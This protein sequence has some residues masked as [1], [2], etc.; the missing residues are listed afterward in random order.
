MA[1][2]H[3]GSRYFGPTDVGINAYSYITHAMSVSVTGGPSIG[4]GVGED[5]D[6]FDTYLSA[7]DDFTWIHG[8]H[9]LAFG[10]NMTHSLISALA[11]VRA[12]GNYTFN[13]QTTGLGSADFMAGFL[14]QLVQ[15]RPNPLYLHQWFVG[16]YAQD[17]WK[18]SPRLTLNAGLRWEP[19]IPM[20]LNDKSIYT[21]S[22]SRHYAGIHSRVWTNAPAGFYYPGDPG[23]NGD[24]GIDSR[25][26]DL[27]PRL[28]LAWDPFGDGKTSIRAGAGL[29]YDFINEQMYLNSDLAAPFY[30]QT[31]VN[32]SIP[33]ANPWSA[34]PT[35]NP[36]PYVSSPPIGT[37]PAFSSFLPLIPNL[38]PPRT[39]TWNAMIQRQV[40]PA[41]FVSA[42]YVGSHS[43]HLFDNIELNPGVYIPGNCAA[44]QYGLTA[45]GPCSNPSNVNYRR[46]LYL[47]YPAASQDIANLTQFDDG[48]TSNYNGLILT[49]Q[50]RPTSNVN[51]NAN[52][53][54]SHCIGDASTGDGTNDVA[55][56]YVHLSDRTLDR[57]NCS[58]D[59]RN[60]FNLTVVTRTPNFANR[61]LHMTLTG[62]SLSTI[63]R[64]SSGASVTMLAG[65]DQSLAGFAP[66][67]GSS[68]RPNQI[69]ANTAAPN[70]GRACAN[71]A[72]CVSWLNPSAFAEPAPGTLGN[73]GTYN[74]VG[75]SYFQLD[76]ALVRQF[77]IRESQN[78]QFR[79]EAFNLFN[80]TRLNATSGGF[81]VS[82]PFSALISSNT[83]GRIFSAFDPRILQLAMK[84]TF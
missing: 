73:M 80:N 10:A 78:L 66:T 8:A 50:W 58:W 31:Y 56:N 13:G 48:A 51:L 60:L 19:L 49:T 2:V 11:Y 20:Q 67:V 7:N 81:G 53:T 38:K 12:I 42:N 77:P 34:L 22:L 47:Q 39:Y 35:G 61:A 59:R 45:P 29:A 71:I 24:A 18:I 72:P 4:S 40:A 32:G 82:L 25:L 79:A 17:T 75:P 21:F 44:G 5:L 36:F 28:G 9:Q 63:Y 23:F 41:L 1:E 64:Y 70:Q 6:N 57:G 84:F 26:G 27:E 46:A 52:Y 83:F 69:L 16:A 62:W 43:Y 14:S 76:V 54:W 55:T 65:I 30:A 74:V 3:P 15:S 33:V 68:E 37:F